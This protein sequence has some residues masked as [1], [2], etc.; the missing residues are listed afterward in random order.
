MSIAGRPDKSWFESREMQ[1]I[2]HPHTRHFRTC[3]GAR[4][5][6]LIKWKEAM[7]IAGRPDKSWFEYRQMQKIPHPHTRDFQTYSGAHPAFCSLVLRGSFRGGNRDA[8]HSPPSSLEVQN[9]WR[10]WPI[11]LSSH[12]L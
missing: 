4:S 10:F 7:L 1:K 3:S 9:D 12:G 5:K 11:L 8:Y 2:P 6:L